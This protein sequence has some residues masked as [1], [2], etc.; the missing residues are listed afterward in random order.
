MMIRERQYISIGKVA[1]LLGVS[2]VTI[3][4]W[5]KLGKINCCF[6]TVGSHR[7][8]DIIKIRE[9][10]LNE[11][12]NKTICYSRVSSADQKNDLKAQVEKLKKYCVDH[13]LENV[14]VIEDVGSGLNFNKKGFKKLFTMI[15]NQQL[16]H[17][18]INHQDRLLRFGAELIFKLCDFYKIKVTIIEKEVETFEKELVTSVL[19]IITVFSSKLYGSRSH[20][21][22]KT[23]GMAA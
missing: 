22:R 12:I 5:E 15:I 23:I 21:N 20:K 2:V 17:L 11:T 7:R 16:N 14:E 3:R 9:Q 13:N 19:E 8:Y 18:V 4:R 6:R 1:K 10:F